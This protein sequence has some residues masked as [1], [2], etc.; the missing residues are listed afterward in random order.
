MGK[1]VVY[2]LSKKFA[3]RIVKLYIFLK[4]ERKEYVMSKQIYRCGTSIGANIA[5]S[6]FA[7]S[8]ADYISKLSIALKEAAE[9]VYWLELL[10]ETDFISTK[11]YESI[12]NDA[13]TIIGTLVNIINKIKNKNSIKQK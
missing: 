10:H 4:E 7:Q 2:E 8:E 3:L 9:T 11:Q 1:S 5:E 6:Q 13:K 12:L